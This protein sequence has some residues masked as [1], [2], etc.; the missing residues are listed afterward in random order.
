MTPS[1]PGQDRL[2]RPLRPVLQELDEQVRPEQEG[3]KGQGIGDGMGEKMGDKFQVDTPFCWK[4]KRTVSLALPLGNQ[5]EDV[6]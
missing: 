5:G 4:I 6:G 1:R 2:Q 3:E